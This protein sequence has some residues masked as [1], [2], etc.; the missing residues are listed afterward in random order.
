MIFFKFPIISRKLRVWERNVP[1]WKKLKSTVEEKTW[2]PLEN[3]VVT[4][5]D[6][7]FRQF[8]FPL[9]LTTAFLFRWISSGVIFRWRFVTKRISTSWTSPLWMQEMCFF[10]VT[11][12]ASTTMNRQLV[13]NNKLILCQ[14]NTCRIFFAISFLII[15]PLSSSRSF[16][17]Y[18]P[19]SFWTSRFLAKTCY[20][21]KAKRNETRL[22]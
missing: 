6:I 17:F 14:E 1:I 5:V 12:S 8:R 21:M 7:S 16:I 4:K 2:K 13:S 15:S 20:G 22:N 18:I 10:R 9:N 11:D 19:V 3:S